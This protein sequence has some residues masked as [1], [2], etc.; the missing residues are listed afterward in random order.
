MSVSMGRVARIAAWSEQHLDSAPI[1]VIEEIKMGVVFF[2]GTTASLL[3][4]SRKEKLHPTIC[5]VAGGRGLFLWFWPSLRNRPC[6]EVELFSAE[7]HLNFLIVAHI[8]VVFSARIYSL[9]QNSSTC[10][11]AR[12]SVFETHSAC[13]PNR[14]IVRACTHRNWQQKPQVCSGQWWIE[15]NCLK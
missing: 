3:F 5:G 1:Q 14:S 10:M 9:K 8:F 15:R 6:S 7:R 12:Q 2:S 4:L 11:H 13:M